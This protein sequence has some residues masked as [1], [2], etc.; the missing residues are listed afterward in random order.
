MCFVCETLKTQAFLE[1]K[2]DKK[3]MQDQNSENS[4]SFYQKRGLFSSKA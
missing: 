2:V 4:E 3:I 1:I